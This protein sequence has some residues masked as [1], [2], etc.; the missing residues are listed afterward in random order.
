M[1][2]KKTYYLGVDSVDTAVHALSSLSFCKAVDSTNGRVQIVY[3]DRIRVGVQ[4]EKKSAG[5]VVFV[6]GSF[7]PEEMSEIEALAKYEHAPMRQTV[8]TV[9]VETAKDLDR[10]GVQTTHHILGKPTVRGEDNK[11]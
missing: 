2:Q 6:S 11:A 4:P 9:V 5:A 7:L 10:N 8:W 3:E 1:L